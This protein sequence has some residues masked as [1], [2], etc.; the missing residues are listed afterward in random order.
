MGRGADRRSVLIDGIHKI[1]PD[2]VGFA[3]SVRTDDYDQTA[4]L[5][6]SEFVVVHSRATKT[7]WVY[8]LAAAGRSPRCMSWT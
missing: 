7:A 4:D 5:L 6:G 3:E 2:I 8:R 1:Q